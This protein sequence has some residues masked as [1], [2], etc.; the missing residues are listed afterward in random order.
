MSWVFPAWLVGFVLG[1][2]F[3]F[4][5][6]TEVHADEHH[7][8]VIAACRHIL[9]PAMATL[10]PEYEHHIF[11]RCVELQESAPW[12]LRVEQYQ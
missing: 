5:V 2:A 8:E 11:R 4:F 3:G 6:C 7:D 9:S 1:L 10:H 12:R